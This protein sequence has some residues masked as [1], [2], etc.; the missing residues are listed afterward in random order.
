MSE[1][2]LL[3]GLAP[4]IDAQTRVIVLG[5]FPGV[6]SLQAQQYYGHPRNHFWPLLGV[7]WGEPGLHQ[8]P[9]A[10]KL[11][12]A[13]EHGLGLWDVYAEC[14][15]E[16]SLDSAIREPRLNDLASLR[17]RA[18]GLRALAHNGAESAKTMRITGALGWPVLKLPSTSP[19]HASWSLDQKLAAWRDALAPFGLLD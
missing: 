8:R 16:G 5:S 3:T 1:S 15:R 14:R 17:D 18:P 19:A 11:A 12:A 13:R 4:V 7:L 10:D 9:Y 6:A 2:E